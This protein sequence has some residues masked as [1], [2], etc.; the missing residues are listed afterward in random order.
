LDGS[1]VLRDGFFLFR[2]IF[3]FTLLQHGSREEKKNT[4]GRPIIIKTWKHATAQDGIL[5]QLYLLS[6]SFFFFF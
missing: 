3:I 5:F 6:I 4:V 2:N 1:S